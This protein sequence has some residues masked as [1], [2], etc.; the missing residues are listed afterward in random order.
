MSDEETDE[1]VER[2]NEVAEWR[3]SLSGNSVEHEIH[4][5]V[6]GIINWPIEVVHHQWHVLQDSKGKEL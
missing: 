3:A 2:I 4:N 6:D 5:D 1:L